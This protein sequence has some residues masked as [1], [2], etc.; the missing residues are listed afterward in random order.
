MKKVKLTVAILLLAA[1]LVGLAACSDSEAVSAY[2]LAVKNGFVGT[3]QEWLDSLRGQDG[4]DGRDGEDGQ[5]YITLQDIYQVARDNGYDGDI[6]DFIAEYLKTEEYDVTALAAGKGMLSSVVVIS[7]FTVQINYFGSVQTETYTAGGGG[8][9]YRLDKEK[10]DAYIITNFH[11][12][13][14]HGNMT[15]TG[16][17][18]NVKVYIYGGLYS[19]KAVSA[20]V[21]GGSAYYDIAVLRVSDSEILKNSDCKAVELAENS[22]SVGQ[23]AVAIGYPSGKGF[24]VTSGVVSVDSENISVA[25]DGVNTYSLR[26]MRIDTAVNSGNS[27]G[28][29]FNSAGKLIGIVNAKNGDTSVENVSFAIPADVAVAVADNVIDNSVNSSTMWLRK[30]TIGITS[31][32][33]DSKMVYNPNTGLVGIE[34]TVVVSEVVS[35]GLCDGVLVSG[36]VLIGATLSGKSVDITRNY[37]LSDLMLSARVGDEITLVFLRNG[38][39]QSVVITMTEGCVA[40]YFKA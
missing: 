20:T 10:G 30:C 18:D 36:D 12:V 29:L 34:E 27:G 28:G 4:A 22:V 26:C 15:E 7:E 32:I 40:D 1:L 25:V 38:E 24:S 17:S 19:D 23:T 16:F 3:E 13:Y 39:R 2:E 8:V 11:V 35:G 6:L 33:T 5:S 31:T 37:V 9:I 21:V 14:E